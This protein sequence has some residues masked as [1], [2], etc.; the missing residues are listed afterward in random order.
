MRIETP[1]SHLAV[2]SL[3]FGIGIVTAS[4]Y[5]PL[6][7]WVLILTG[8][9]LAIRAL[10]LS[11]QPAT[12]LTPATIN[13][14][15]VLASIALVWTGL[16]EGLLNGMLNLLLVGMALKLLTLQ[17]QTDF[18]QLFGCGIF[19]VSCHFI[20]DQSMASAAWSLLA[21]SSLLFALY[22]HHASRHPL[23]TQARAYMMMALQATPITLLLFITLPKLP[24]LWKV[25]TAKGA[26]TGLSDVVTP[27]DI[28]HLARSSKLAFT[29]EFADAVPAPAERY[30]RAITL[31]QFDGNHW[32]TAPER[33]RQGVNAA[34]LMRAQGVRNTAVPIINYHVIAEPS[35]QSY[36]FAID[37][38]ML[39][40][41]TVPVYHTS[42][43]QLRAAQPVNQAQRY[44]VRSWLFD[45]LT[46]LAPSRERDANVVLPD[47]SNPKAV[48]WAKQHMASS[49]TAEDF[50]KTV[51]DY[52]TANA[53]SYTL[54]PPP[55]PVNAVDTFLFDYQ[56]G[57]CAHY[58]SALVVLL[59]AADIPARMVTGYLGGEMID[60]KVMTVRQYD[61][62][63]WVEYMTDQGA[64]RRLDPTAWVAPDRV[65]MGLSD[66]MLASGQSD[67]LGGLHP[68]RQFAW[69]SRLSVWM[70][71]INYQWNRWV[72][73]FSEE[74]QRDLIKQLLGEVTVKRLLLFG[75]LSMGTVVMLFAVYY[76]KQWLTPKGPT[77]VRHFM[78]ALAR[79]EKVTGMARHAM[80]P[81]TFVLSVKTHLTAQQ[82]Q[83]LTQLND[84]FERLHYQGEHQDTLKEKRFRDA[85]RR[86]KRVIKNAAP[87]R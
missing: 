82:Y 39:G 2:W 64:W 55:M 71:Q 66:M 27:G 23:R 53:F 50:I 25:P 5:Q 46:P 56:T 40:T 33:Q 41:S 63:A 74:R 8:C 18:H 54:T 29:V 42:D 35:G 83:A 47:N 62:H 75:A 16:G 37:L 15:G 76:R 3:L 4:L 65:D 49:A 12:A 22:L 11:E 72:I 52:F 51:Q 48:A 32:T 68:L 13:L 80:S 84:A 86:F 7:S 69:F 81:R 45:S 26:S 44:A 79:V 17:R 19:A 20:F 77:Y 67:L 34:T 60:D 21:C 1:L 36:L 24:P 43:F 73:G 10:V 57:F 58:A 61:A 59:R 87:L 70:S 28:A 78:S 6:Q 14:L 31:E 38:A 30:W 9:A 85:L